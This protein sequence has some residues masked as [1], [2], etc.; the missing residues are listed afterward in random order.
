MCKY[1]A[2]K[3]GIKNKLMFKRYTDDQYRFLTEDLTPEEHKI[4]T[5][6]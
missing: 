3:L 4:F 5:K 1:K 6:N 2:W